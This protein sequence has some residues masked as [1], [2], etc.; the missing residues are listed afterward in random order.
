MKS[1]LSVRDIQ[2]QKKLYKISK[3]IKLSY[4]LKSGLCARD[5]LRLPRQVGQKD[6]PQCP[7]IP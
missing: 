5:V 2:Q 4:I 3:N 1:G 7:P 6:R